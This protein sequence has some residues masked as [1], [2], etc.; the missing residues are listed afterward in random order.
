MSRWPSALLTIIV[1]FA[2]TAYSQNQ[3][4]EDAAICLGVAYFL[5]MVLPIPFVYNAN[6]F[7]FWTP[8]LILPSLLCFF[9]SAFLLIDNK[10]AAK[11][12]LVGLAICCLVAIQCAIEVVMLA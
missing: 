9:L 10:F 2:S 4:R 12:R 3:Q 1:P 5:L 8:R 7:G 11:S 6:L